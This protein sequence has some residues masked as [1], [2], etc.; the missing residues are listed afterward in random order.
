ME[1]A[2]IIT[3]IAFGEKKNINLQKSMSGRFDKS[4]GL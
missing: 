2:G 1:D 4:L 3:K